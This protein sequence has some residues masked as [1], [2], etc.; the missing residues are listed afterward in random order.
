M[1]EL[2]SDDEI[3]KNGVKQKYNF[4][5][6]KICSHAFLLYNIIGNKDVNETNYHFN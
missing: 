2:I 1:F 3:F 4:P 6:G 5:N